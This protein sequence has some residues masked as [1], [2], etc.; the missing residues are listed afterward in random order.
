MVIIVVITEVLIV[1]LASSG[2]AAAGNTSGGKGS[3]G[4]DVHRGSNGMVVI[5]VA[6][7]VV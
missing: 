7:A 3:V 6:E 4:R 1:T 2:R 5:V